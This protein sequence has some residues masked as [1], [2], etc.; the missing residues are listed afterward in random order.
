MKFDLV[1]KDII[2]NVD[3]DFSVIPAN[4]GA[5][6]KFKGALNALEQAITLHGNGIVR[7]IMFA[8]IFLAIINI[9]RIAIMGQFGTTKTAAEGKKEIVSTIFLTIFSL[10]VIGFVRLLAAIASGI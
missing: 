3:P 6:A 7:L 10:A 8:I 1:N 5:G 2:H 4:N 9:L